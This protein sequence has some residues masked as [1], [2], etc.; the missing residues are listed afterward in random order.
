MGGMSF[1]FFLVVVLGKGDLFKYW[2]MPF[3]PC[4]A[5]LKVSGSN[6]YWG[7]FGC[8]ICAYIGVFSRYSGLFD[9]ALATGPGCV[10]SL[11]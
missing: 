6:V 8:F 11:A 7:L 5:Q 1:F 10:W 3:S 4:A 9:S 2:D